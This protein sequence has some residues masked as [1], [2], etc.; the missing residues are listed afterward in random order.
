VAHFCN[1]SYLE[2]LDQE[3]QV[4]S[5]ARQKSLQDTTLAEKKLS[6]VAHSCF[7]HY[8]EKDCGPGLP[9]EKWETC[10]QNNQSKKGWGCGSSGRVPA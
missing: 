10:L 8:E 9:G 7:L 3:D 2:G 5:P 6:I 1:P 4:S